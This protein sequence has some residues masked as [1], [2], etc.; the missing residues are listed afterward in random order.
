MKVMIDIFI[1]ENAN[2]FPFSTFDTV[3]SVTGQPTCKTVK[4][5]FA[6]AKG[7]YDMLVSQNLARWC[8]DIQNIPFEKAC[9]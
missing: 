9:N 4:R 6:I 1:A 7:P 3:V 5:S 2:A 8:T